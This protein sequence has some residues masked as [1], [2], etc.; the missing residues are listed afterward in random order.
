MAKLCTSLREEMLR[1]ITAL[2]EIFE[3]HEISSDDLTFIRFFISNMNA[4]STMDHVIDKVLPWSTE[5]E[6]RDD[7]FFYNHM[8]IFGK[9]PKDKVS[10]FADVWKSGKLTDEDKDEIWSFFDTFAECAR[11]FKKKD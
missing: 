1:F 8:D 6:K 3:D 11:E 7:E 4:R 2:E 9:L 10:Y 5:I